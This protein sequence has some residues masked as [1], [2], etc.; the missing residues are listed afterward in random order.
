[1]RF[2]KLSLLLNLL[3]SSSLAFAETVS[4]R[5]VIDGINHNT[6]SLVARVYNKDNWLSDEPL[7][8]KSQALADDYS[9]GPLSIDLELD[10]GSY[11]FAVYHDID[12]N[13]EMEK[14]Y[15][16]IPEEPVGLSNGHRPRF[17]PPR[18]KK[19]VLKISAE[20]KQISI[21]LD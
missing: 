3:L 15:F 11:A 1:M 4:L 6:G 7:M 12:G 9:G 21:T 17:G 18:Y 19:A 2:I 5:V 8:S 16:G 10:E 13:G 20:T 14:N